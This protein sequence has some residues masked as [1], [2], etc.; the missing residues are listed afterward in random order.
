MSATA[1]SASEARKVL[2]RAE[3]M[4]AELRKDPQDIVAWEAILTACIAILRSVGHVLDK[5]DG[6]TNPRLRQSIDSWWVKIKEGEQSK[7]PPI[8]WAFIDEERN[9][10]LKKNQLRTGES[11]MVGVVGVRAYALVAGQVPPLPQPQQAFR[12]E[13]RSVLFLRNRSVAKAS[14]AAHGHQPASDGYVRPR[15]G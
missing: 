5:V 9:L 14:M 13:A 7:N 15:V 6:K 11:T 8:F 10:I 1:C 3:H 12:V 2:P 4:L